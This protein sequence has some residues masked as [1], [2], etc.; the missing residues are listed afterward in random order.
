MEKIPVI[1]DT[2]IGGDIDDTWALAYLLSRPELDLKLVTISSQ[3]PRY[4]AKIVAK[5]CQ[6][7]GFENIPIGL[8]FRMATNVGVAEEP[9]DQRDWVE[10]YSIDSY[11]GEVYDDGI[12]AL[13]DCIRKSSS[14]IMLIT[15]G[16]ASNI[17]DALNRAPDIADKVI[18]KSMFGSIYKGYEGPSKC[19][20][21][22]VVT[23]IPA[24]K[25][26]ISGFPDITITPLDTC[27]DIP[28]STEQYRRL[29]EKENE[30]VLVKALL[31]NHRIWCRNHPRWEG[32]PADRWDYICDVAAIYLAYDE[33]LVN[34]E[35]LP[36]IVD[37]KGYMQIDNEKG[38]RIRAAL[39]WTDNNK[40]VDI[41]ID[42]LLSFKSPEN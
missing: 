42:S 12:G 5:F 36:I 41:M 2:D 1:L 17:A 22:N 16:P 10:D 34:I 6:T 33:S 24:A 9:L 38:N 37:D 21:C 27:F 31:E 29:E 23:D 25:R 18:L 40:F 4:A 8:G 39:T 26:M 20:E 19:T 15:I 13:I 28:S 3:S 7:V 35:T 11:P 32:R 14:K 30:N